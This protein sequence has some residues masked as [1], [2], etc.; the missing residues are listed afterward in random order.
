MRPQL[1]KTSLKT[2]IAGICLINLNLPN[3]TRNKQTSK[4]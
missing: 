3:K 1:I 2:P 4:T